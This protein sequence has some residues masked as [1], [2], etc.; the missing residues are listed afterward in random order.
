M[1]VAASRPISVRHVTALNRGDKVSAA[2]SSTRTSSSVNTLGSLGRYRRLRVAS[3]GICVA[4]SRACWYRAKIRTASILR[5]NKASLT[6]T[7][8]LAV[9]HSTA[10]SFWTRLAPRASQNPTKLSNSLFRP[11]TLKPIARRMAR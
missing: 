11:S 2:A 1:P 7:L 3:G 6:G 8:I 5:A 10:R 4:G 9:A